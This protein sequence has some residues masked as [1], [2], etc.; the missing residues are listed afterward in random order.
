MVSYLE[1]V[2]PED[3][4]ILYYQHE[5]TGGCSHAKTEG[6]SSGYSDNDES[7]DYEPEIVDPKT[8]YPLPDHNI[9]TFPQEN[10][11]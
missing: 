10:R 8:L 7:E 3:D 6:A 1:S 2:I 9:P 11:Q 5:S 4:E